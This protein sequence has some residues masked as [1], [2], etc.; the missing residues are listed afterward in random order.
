M[1][2]TQDNGSLRYTPGGGTEGW[3]AMFGGDGGFSAA[4]QTDAKWFPVRGTFQEFAMEVHLRNGIKTI[5][6]NYI[7]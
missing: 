7:Q 1:G 2:G 5:A 6:L 3:T 4:D